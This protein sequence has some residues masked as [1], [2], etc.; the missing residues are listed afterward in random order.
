MPAC[1]RSREDWQEWNRFNRET[2][3]R[4]LD[5][6]CADCSPEFQ[7]RMKESLR[8]IHPT[9]TFVQIV[10]RQYNPR[11]HVRREVKT[12]ALKGVRHET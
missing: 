4:P 5:H 3:D 2:L 8:C 11:E 7:R 1:W 9:V 12:N 6:F 10:E